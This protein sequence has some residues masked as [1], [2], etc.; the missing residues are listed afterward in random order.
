[1][2][3]YTSQIAQLLNKI[4]SND[5]KAIVLY[6]YNRGFISAIINQIVK[7]FDLL[8]VNLD[9]KDL[10]RSNLELLAN[11]TNL[12]QKREMLKIE[13]KGSAISKEL[14]EF[15]VSGDFVNF[16]CFVG[17]ESLPASGIRKAFEDSNNLVSM[18]CYDE[19]DMA[20]KLATVIAA[21]F[22][23]TVSSEALHYL[24]ANLRGDYQL[25]KSEIDK[26]IYYT[27]DKNQISYEDAKAVVSPGLEASGDEM[28][29]FFS[30]EKA[31]L[32]LSEVERLKNQN[33]N[34]ILI[35]RALIRYYIN[36]F[37]VTS[38]A[39]NS[40]MKNSIELE[41]AIKTL[42]PPIFF[43]YLG[44]FRQIAQKLTPI[45]S[46]RIIEILQKAEIKFKNNNK[47]F[48]F[49]TQLYLPCFLKN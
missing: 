16:I 32:F 21:R 31:E 7:K 24:K 4:A 15:L 30:G 25:I 43:K 47:D 23:K 2:K 33:I 10:T 26:L 39:T 12:F 49:Y 9:Q 44:H 36:L 48:D 29:I 41:K 38:K 28:C 37:I 18:P 20:T 5:V 27:H 3:L 6:G 13:Y 11:S 35:I 42:S 14:K 1:M 46:L 22:N 40:G 17:E 19:D 8:V 34:E 45:E